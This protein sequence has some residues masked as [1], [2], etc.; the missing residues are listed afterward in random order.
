MSDNALV[1]RKVESDADMKAFLHFPWTCYK[2]NPNWVPPLYSEHKAF[3]DRE[4]NPELHHIDIDYFVAWRDDKP[5]GIIAALVNHAH[6]EFHEENIGFFGSFEVLEDRGAGRALLDTAQAWCRA[7]GV[8]AVRGPATFSI[9]S[10]IGLLVEGYD[11]PPMILNTHAHPYYKDFVESAGFEKVMDLWAY[12]VDSRIFG[13]KKA[14]VIPE[15][16]ARVVDKIRRRRNFTVRKFN[17]RNFDDEVER[18]KKIYNSAWEKNWGFIPFSDAE[19]DKMAQDLKQLVD[20]DIT[21]FVEVDGEPVAF[22]LP[23][24]NLYEP[25]RLAYPRPD[26]LEILAL[27][28]LVW[29]WKIR[30]RLTSLRMWAMGV[31]EEYRGTGVDALIYYEVMMAGL[32]KGYVDVEMSW[33]L[34]NNDMMNRAVRMLGGRLYKTYRIYE[35]P[36]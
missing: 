4:K 29:H 35:K 33:V 20:P 25:L 1:V 23:L 18:L 11:T 32:R 17:M 14:D 34:E 31:L 24:P 36:L 19:I 5:V 3:Y 26:E 7:K 2:G 21:F 12:H 10:E 6:N 28:R 30:R 8:T 9:N 13:G 27:L 16:L 15:K 22:G